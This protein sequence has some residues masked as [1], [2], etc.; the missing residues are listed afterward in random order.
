LGEES[1]NILIENNF[2]HHITDKGISVGQQSTIQMIGNTVVECNQGLGIK[3][4]GMAFVDQNTFYNNAF[5]IV[6][7]EKNVGKGGGH[8]QI[9]NSIFSNTAYDPITA[10]ETSSYL[11]EYSLSDTKELDGFDLIFEDPSFENPTQNDFHLMG[12]SPAINGGFDSNGSI[13]DLGAKSHLYSAKGSLLISGIHY[14]PLD[15]P[16]KEFLQIYNPSTESN[17]ISYYEISD[18][19]F[20]IFPTGTIIEPGETIHLVKDILLYPDLAGQVFEWT[21]GKLANGGEQLILKDPYG[22]ILDHVTYSFESPWPTLAD[23]GGGYLK[24]ID[25]DLDNHFGKNW[26]GE[27]A[28][29]TRIN[30]VN[31]SRAFTIS[32]N[33]TE[34]FI[35]ILSLEDRIK[36]LAVFDAYGRECEKISVDQSSAKI[37]LQALPSGIYYLVI[38]DVDIKKV[39]KI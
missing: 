27:L 29:P 19:V 3:D 35:E 18:G 11:L 5:D 24:L 30:E 13:I 1:E 26:I 31:S 6:A 15:D 39:V 14:N 32:P 22:I 10:D 23:G 21:S 33:P 16:D 12:N 17:D 2:I 34:G 4:E 7:F 38:N 37:N 36:T 8:L 20:F 25:S 28:N 9:I